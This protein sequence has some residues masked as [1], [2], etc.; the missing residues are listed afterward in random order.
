M[1]EGKGHL[2][3]QKPTQSSSANSTASRLGLGG[4]GQDT[5]G[6]EQWEDTFVFNITLGFDPQKGFL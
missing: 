1:E 3:M 4:A 5:S 2:K 6:G